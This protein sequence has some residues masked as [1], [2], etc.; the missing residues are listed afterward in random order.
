MTRANT[1][2]TSRFVLEAL[3]GTRWAEDVVGERISDADA[4]ARE[5]D[6]AAQQRLA[7]IFEADHAPVLFSGGSLAD[8]LLHATYHGGT[9][10]DFLTGEDV[11]VCTMHVVA[12]FSNTSE[13]GRTEDAIKVCRVLVQEGVAVRVHAVLDGGGRTPRSAQFE[14]ERFQEF[15]PEAKIVTL[16]GR[17]VCLGD[18]SWEHLVDV[19]RAFSENYE[20]ELRKDIAE[21]LEV[22]YG[23][24]QLDRDLKPVRVFPFRGVSGDLQCDFAATVPAWEWTGRDV[25][26]FLLRSGSHQA[27]L[28]SV[29]TRRD[30]PEEIAAK[31]SVRGRAVVTFESQRIGSLV[32]VPGFSHMGSLPAA[33]AIAFD[34][35]G[36]DDLART[37]M[38]DASNVPASSVETLRERFGSRGLELVLLDELGVIE[39]PR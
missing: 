26:L 22:A 17:D 27:R 19:Q 36:A 30:L 31:V 37:A 2:R 34:E 1:E 6:F 23:A 8:Q 14:L 38:T 20:G 25:A 16:M 4:L 24:G 5:A 13:L 15:V 33:T 11:P 3:P 29:L 10:S 18:A 9:V 39:A 21:A 35:I 32:P 12:L 7:A 28:A